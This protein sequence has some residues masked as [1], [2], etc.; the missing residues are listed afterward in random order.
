MARH[1]HGLI[2]GKFLPPHAGH[3]F[4][5]RFASGFADRLTVLVCSI[6][7]EPIAGHLRYEWMREMF[8]DARVVHVTDELP[9]APHEHPGF[10]DMWRETVLAAVCEPI[11]YVFASEAYGERLA[12]EVGARFIPVDIA[13]QQVRVSGTL[14]RARPLEYWDFIPPCVRPYFVKRVCLFGPE[15]TGK[16]SLAARLARHFQTEYVAEFARELL[17]PKQGVCS[18]EDIPLIARGQMA[19]EDALARRANRVLICD[20]DVLLTTVWSDVLFGTCPDGV[21]RAAEERAY[22]LYLL[23]DIDAPWIDDKQRF[24]PHRRQD[25][26]DRCRTTLERY[27][28][29]YRIVRGDWDERFRQACREI[30]SLLLGERLSSTM[31]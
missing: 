27:G 4:L 17:N 13:R 15:S 2:L 16:S 26:F 22:D 5:V 25:F 1:G 29:P 28:R 11:D 14:I 3:E 30:E 23:L 24:L 18:A 10:W 12:A 9:Q 7:R 21:R 8:P 19:A 31:A 6:A 20:T